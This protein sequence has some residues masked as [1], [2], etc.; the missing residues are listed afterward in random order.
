MNEPYSDAYMRYD[1]LKHR[2]I[3]TPKCVLDELG[4]DMEARLSAK[5]SANPQATI[6]ALLHRVSA[7][8][9]RFIYAHNIDNEA[10]RYAIET[11]PSARRILFEAMKAQLTY[12]MAGGDLSI[13]SDKNKRLQ[14]MDDVAAEMLENPLLELGHSLIYTGGWRCW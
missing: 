3:L 6:N 5:G 14:Y 1:E 10:Q 12:V 4:I 13:S 2:Y 8:T 11:L 9:Y 7:L